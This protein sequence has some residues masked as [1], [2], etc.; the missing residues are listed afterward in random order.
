MVQEKKKL[1]VAVI[2]DSPVVMDKKN[3][4]V[5]VGKLAGRVSGEG[6]EM[7]QA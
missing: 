4:L 3:T 7:I 6:A 5:K 1:R 2:Q